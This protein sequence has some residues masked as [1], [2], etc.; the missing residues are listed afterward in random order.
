M[1]INKHKLTFI[2]ISKKLLFYLKITFFKRKVGAHTR[3]EWRACLK[4]NKLA[5]HHFQSSWR[6]HWRG[7]RIGIPEGFHLEV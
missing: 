4:G 7:C 5:K 6:K 2:K 3:Y 1:I